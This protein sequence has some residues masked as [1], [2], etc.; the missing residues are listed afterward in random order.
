MFVLQII[1]ALEE[2][3][4]YEIVKDKEKFKEL[5][6]TLVRKLEPSEIQQRVLYVMLMWNSKQKGNLMIF[7][8][9]SS[10]RGQQVHADEVTGVQ[11]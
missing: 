8:S 2:R 10:K 5:T 7:S 6:K 9:R 1:S 11:L 3:N 4:A